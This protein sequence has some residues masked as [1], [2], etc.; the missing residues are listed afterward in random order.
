M[1]AP[2]VVNASSYE[3]NG[4]FENRECYSH[5]RHD[6]FCSA[7]V[8]RTFCMS[9]I[10]DYVAQRFLCNRGDICSATTKFLFVIRWG[11]AKSNHG[12]RVQQQSFLNDP[13]V[14]V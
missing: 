2:L 12:V 3:N 7:R 6:A 9:R 14:H 8:P 11:G 13:S 5:A 10:L 4:Q 1:P